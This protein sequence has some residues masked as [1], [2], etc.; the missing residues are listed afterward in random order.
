MT[1]VP[2]PGPRTSPDR[3][4]AWYLHTADAIVLAG[5]F[6][7]ESAARIAFVRYAARLEESMRRDGGP[8]SAADIQACVAKLRVGYGVRPEPD[9]RFLAVSRDDAPE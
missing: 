7:G 2:A 3:V 1:R 6:A 9:R 8:C 5:P 4:P